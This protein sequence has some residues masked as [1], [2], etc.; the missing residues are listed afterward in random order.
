MIKLYENVRAL[1]RAADRHQDLSQAL[2]D[3]R[4]AATK[5]PPRIVCLVGSTRFYD[6]FVRA[7]YD[8]TMAGHIVLSVGFAPER[9]PRRADPRYAVRVLDPEFRPEVLRGASHGEAVGATPEQKLRLD[10]LHKRKIDLANAV[11]VINVGG[12]VGES[13][14]GEIEYAHRAGKPV[15]WLEPPT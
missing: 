7:N 4:R 11:L 1:L 2:D 8:E 6:A 5:F 3:L 13:T 9:E 15:R 12:Y 14:R 10:E